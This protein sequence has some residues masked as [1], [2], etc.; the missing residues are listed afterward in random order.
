VVSLVFIQHLIEDTAMKKEANRLKKIRQ[1]LKSIVPSTDRRS[2]ISPLSFVVNL[3]FCYLGDTQKTSLES[4]RREMK[5][6]LKTDIS[7]SAFWER[8]SRK[9]LKKF[10][11]LVVSTLMSQLSG[12][13]LVGAEI[14]SLLGVSGIFLVD[15]SSFTLWDGAKNDYPGTFTTASIKWH[16]CF[17]LLSGRL[18]WFELTPTNVHDRKRFPE[19][20]QFKGKL[21]I[22]DLGYWDYA[23]LLSIELAGGYFLSRIKSNATLPIIELV[24]GLP[25]KH[26][27]K[28]INSIK[29]KKK[30][31]KKYKDIVEVK[32]EK[33]VGDQWLR[34][35]AIGFWN[36][37]EYKYHWY[38]SNLKV[39][40]KIMY[41]L[42]RL[43]WQI[44]LI[45]K[46]A[47]Q[48]LNANR[49]TSNNS[50]IIESLLLASLAAQLISMMIFRV[51]AT[52]LNE[53]QLLARSFQ[54]ISKIAGVLAKDFVNFFLRLSKHPFKDLVDKIILFAKDLFDPNYQH[55]ETSLMR[56][57]R[58]LKNGI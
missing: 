58:E 31:N 21:V 14:L 38:L 54:R 15:S 24:E 42:Y 1:S 32:T 41:P 40:A 30:N 53:E 34:C 4:I 18:S 28:L 17:N 55:R 25:K 52:Q 2:V 29:L 46:G 12:G 35:R 16:A 37:G 6:N 45:F 50:N 5:S 43:R 9:R 49:L 36:P 11:I 8:L 20:R 3:I 23:L 7:R 48:S 39:P 22:F 57:D 26:Q 47:Q 27:G 44:E 51:G 19:L 33:K 56:L 10:L 13:V